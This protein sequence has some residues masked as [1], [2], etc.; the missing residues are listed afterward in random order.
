MLAQRHTRSVRHRQGEVCG[1][2][3]FQRPHC[4]E[5]HTSLGLVAPDLELDIDTALQMRNGPRDPG[6]VLVGEID[7]VAE[8]LLGLGVELDV[9]KGAADDGGALALV[10]GG[11]GDRA[12]P[13]AD[14][15]DAEEDEQGGAGA[16]GGE[17]GGLG[18]E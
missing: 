9:E 12:G 10:V 8:E 15:E 2:P 6:P 4:H 7:V 11:N 16:D 1:D 17:F 13:E 14:A 3:L 5:M 18:F